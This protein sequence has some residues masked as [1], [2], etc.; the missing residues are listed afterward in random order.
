M[1]IKQVTIQPHFLM[2]SGLLMDLGKVWRGSICGGEI[3]KIQLYFI[4]GGKLEFYRDDGSGDIET[5]IT[6]ST[7]IL[8][9]NDFDQLR[10]YL[11]VNLKPIEIA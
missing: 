10:A 5:P 2:V 11:M 3:Q 1:A 8:Y 7:V 9:A 4:G 6:E